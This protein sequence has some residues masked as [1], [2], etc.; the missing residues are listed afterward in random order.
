V[1]VEDYRGAMTMRG[2]Y[3][4][5]SWS[6]AQRLF[7]SAGS[8]LDNGAVSPQGS[9]TVLPWRSTRLQ[10]SWGQYAQFPDEQSL[11]SP[12]GSRGLLPERAS[13]LAV[14]LEQR[15]GPMARLRVTACRRRDRDLLFR[16]WLE[17]RLGPDG[18]VQ[19]DDFQ[20]PLL[21][22][23]SGEAKGVEFFLQ[24]RTANQLT[25]WVSYALGWVRLHDGVT[26]ARFAA[27]QDQR[28]TAN[29]YLE[30]RLVQAFMLACDG[31]TGAASGSRLFSPRRR[32]LD[33]EPR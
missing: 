30:Y 21:N 11:F 16:P 1:R 7:V 31:H 28:H 3:A 10:V 15:L 22:S 12:Y 9:V 4:Q 23:V 27:D 26:G 24:R 17:A 19:T 33:A 2:G 32:W 18:A 14:A 8:R 29:I 6:L 20:S 25:G 5:Q 13:H